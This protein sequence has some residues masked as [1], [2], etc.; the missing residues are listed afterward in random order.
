VLEAASPGEVTTRALLL[1]L[2]GFGTL[3]LGG[4][5]GGTIVFV[6]GIRVVNLVDE[7]TTDAA[8][9][10]VTPEQEAAAAE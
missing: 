8:A 4:R 5:L 7:P 3:T 6:Y 2:V 10:V 1:T 9:P